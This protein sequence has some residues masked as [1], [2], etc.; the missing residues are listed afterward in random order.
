[1]EMDRGSSAESLVQPHCRQF[2]YSPYQSLNTL[3]SPLQRGQLFKFS[4][5]GLLLFCIVY[6]DYLAL[7]LPDSYLSVAFGLVINCQMA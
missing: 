1:M 5:S 6:P 2:S 4:I 3:T 7:V